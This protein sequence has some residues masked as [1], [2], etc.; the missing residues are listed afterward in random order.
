MSYPIDLSITGKP[1]P[2]VE[3]PRSAG[4]RSQTPL[5]VNRA[6]S[7]QSDIF[8]TKEE[9][10][11]ASNRPKSGAV[12]NPGKSKPKSG[13]KFKQD[14]VPPSV[15]TKAELASIRNLTKSTVPEEAGRVEYGVYESSRKPAPKGVPQLSLDDIIGTDDLA[16]TRAPQKEDYDSPH[17]DS[18]SWGTPLKQKIKGQN[19]KGGGWQV[20]QARQSPVKTQSSR[21]HE[22]VPDLDL[23]LSQSNEALGQLREVVKQVDDDLQIEYLGK[24]KQEL[25]HLKKISKDKKNQLFEEAILADQLSNLQTTSTCTSTQNSTQYGP[26]LKRHNDL[27]SSSAANSGCDA[28]ISKR[29]RFGA[30]VLSL[31]GHDS[32]RE[33]NGFFITSDNTVAMYEFRQFGTRSKALPLIHRGSYRHVSGSRKGEAIHLLDI[34]PNKNLIFETACQSC[35]PDSLKKRKYVTFRITDV[36]EEDKKSLLF[37]G[38]RTD[39]ERKEVQDFVRFYFNREE[40]AEQ[41]YIRTFQSTLRNSLKSCGEKVLTN[42]YTHLQKIDK[43][44]GGLLTKAELKETLEKFRI[45]VENQDFEKVWQILNA[46]DEGIMDYGEFIRGYL[47][48]MSEERKLL[49][50]RAFSR[51]DPNKRGIGELNDIRKYFCPSKHPTVLKGDLTEVQVLD[52]FIQ[53][54][55]PSRLKTEISFS[56][57]EAYYEGLSCGIDSDQ[58]FINLLRMIWNI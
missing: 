18:V 57:F 40:N 42:I 44:G 51:I 34:S 27:H 14:E 12:N 38:C 28:D 23:K 58:S 17:E 53:C 37:A 52:E 33:I 5:N 26:K 56:E 10:L 32:R 16:F 54:F 25:D 36:D 19:V 15:L 43:S 3:H 50:R 8:S 1:T 29:L 20:S 21:K 13:V 47:G 35:I 7:L 31:N 11:G 22:D 6:R 4:K 45:D 49:V 48:E 46:D 9:N 24:P 39:K 30:R 2:R 55:K 41:D